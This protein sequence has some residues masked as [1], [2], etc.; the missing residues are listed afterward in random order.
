MTKSKALAKKQA[1]SNTNWK[2]YLLLT[3][4]AVCILGAYFA[5][6]LFIATAL[7][8]EK[9]EAYVHIGSDDKYDDVLNQLVLDF[10]LKNVNLFDFFANHLGYTK[11]VRPGRYKVSKHITLFQLLKLL[12][13]GAQAPVNLTFV[14]FRR[15][16]ELC[17]AIAKKIEADSL[18]LHTALVNEEILNR[19]GLNKDAGLALFIPNT[20]ELYWNTSS[21]ELIERMYKAF[22]TFWN[23]ERLNK[24]D[25][26]GLNAVQV[27]ILASIVQEETNKF[28]EMPIIAGVY[29]NRLKKNM[30]LQADPTVRF[31][32]NDF[33]IKRVLKA[34]TQF[35]SAYNTYQIIGLPPGPIC[36]PDSRAIDAVLNLEHHQYLYFCAKD[37][38]SGFHNFASNY[39]DHL[40]NAAKF[41]KELNK[42]N[43][44]R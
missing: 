35:F 44:Y 18:S 40:I 29:Y 11:S 17:A 31:A 36:T 26:L 1:P 16:N 27:S 7:K 12:K 28:A 42:R 19:Y 24:A 2:Q 25:A 6:Q 20:Y 37:D 10:Q 21:I 13:S 23:Q 22:N 32:L 43:I 8:T 33:T 30:P 4:L 3:F 41:H 5:Y 9:A 34:H 38:F 39:Q 15:I 14:K